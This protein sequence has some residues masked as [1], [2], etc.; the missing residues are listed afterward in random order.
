VDGAVIVTTPFPTA[1]SDAARAADL[2]RDD[3]VPVLGT[4]RNMAA[5]ECPTIRCSTSYTLS[6]CGS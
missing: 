5:F 3:G 6:G 1:A 4:V 2:F